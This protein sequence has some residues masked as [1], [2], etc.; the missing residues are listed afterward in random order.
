MDCAPNAPFDLLRSL[1]LAYDAFWWVRWGQQ[2]QQQQPYTR[3]HLWMGVSGPN[4][5]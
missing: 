3:V 1:S 5:T 2:Q 4:T